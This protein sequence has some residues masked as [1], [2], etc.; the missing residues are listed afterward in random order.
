VHSSGPR[1]VYKD[2]SKEKP[3]SDAD[4][5]AVRRQLA[6]KKGM[7]LFKGKKCLFSKWGALN[8]WAGLKKSGVPWTCEKLHGEK[9][10][11]GTSSDTYAETPLPLPRGVASQREFQNLSWTR[12]PGMLQVGKKRP[13]RTGR[14]HKKDACA[15]VGR[16]R[17]KT[18]LWEG[19][20]D[21]ARELEKE[22]KSKKCL[23]NG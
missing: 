9:G 14:K 1:E 4:T 20:G 13:P 6:E 3:R 16:A 8:D 19:E 23:V 2:A 21:E 10:A 5:L 11:G 12:T 18:G 15:Y 7:S 17:L 22:L